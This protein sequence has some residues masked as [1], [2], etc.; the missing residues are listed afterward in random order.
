MRR[1]AGRR[2]LTAAVPRPRRLH[3]S[4]PSTPSDPRRRVD[5][6]PT[7]SP[8][9][10]EEPAAEEPGRP[11]ETLPPVHHRVSLPALMR[12]DFGPTRIVRQGLLGTADAYTRHA[13]TYRSGD[14]DR[15]RRP[16]RA[17]RQGPVPGDRAQP[18]LH[19]AVDLRHR[20]GPGP[21]AGLAGPRRVRRAAHRLPRPRRLRPGRP[22]W[23]ARPGSATPR[24]RSTPSAPCE[25]PYVDA[26]QIAM[27]G[28]SMG[29]GVT[30]NALV[31]RP[32]LVDAAVIYASVSSRFLD[33]LRHFTVPEPARG[34]AGAVRPV[35]HARGGAGV[36]PRAC[37]RAPTSTGSPSRC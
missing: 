18:R 29:G 9:G 34:R 19:R 26:D 33:N 14:A 30:L 32:G 2:R 6:T 10:A 11:E 35:R 17:D 31:A 5:P 12:K 13:V 36:L 15:L 1:G 28:R 23:T 21:R 24:T 20:P 8:T 25:E 37:R 7:P 16:A 27:L 4:A 22:T 3:R